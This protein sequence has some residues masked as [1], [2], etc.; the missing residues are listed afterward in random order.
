M[1]WSQLTLIVPYLEID[2]FKVSWKLSDHVRIYNIGEIYRIK[3]TE[4]YK[5]KVGIEYEF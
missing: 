2:K 1:R 4:F 3:Q 5:G